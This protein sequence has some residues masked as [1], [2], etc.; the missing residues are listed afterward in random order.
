MA[1]VLDLEHAS[2]LADILA[3]AE[4]IAQYTSQVIII[5]KVPGIIP[6]LPRT[7]GQADVVLGYSVP[8]RYGGTPV[9]V[10]EFRGWP[11]H[12]LG[13]N[14]LRQKHCAAYMDVVSIDGNYANLVATNF[15]KWFDGRRWHK[16]TRDGQKWGHDAP[17]EC[18]RRSCQGILSLWAKA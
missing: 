12:L 9:P 2:Q 4:D 11:V 16:L 10:W 14:P 15:C 18:F 17:Y 8:T 1:T 5:P 7:I 6:S 13:G 3:W